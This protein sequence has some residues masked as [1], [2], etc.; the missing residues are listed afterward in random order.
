MGE[1]TKQLIRVPKNS[2]HETIRIKGKGGDSHIVIEAEEGSRATII[3]DIQNAGNE[4]VEIT[5]KPNSEIRFATI[6]RLPDC[7]STVQ[8]KAV[9]H[10]NANV[11]WLEIAT[12]GSI[13]KS[14]TTSELL[15]E[16]ARSSIFTLFFGSGKQQF[17]FLNKCIHLG[18]NTESLMLS[19]GALKGTSKATQQGFAKICKG[20]LN[21]AAHQK[22]KILLLDKGARAL[23]MPKLEIDNNEVS[24][25]HEAAVGQIDE[26]KIFY[27]MSRG[28][29]EK[30]ARKTFVEGFFEQYASRIDVPELRKDIQAIVAERMEND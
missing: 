20:A 4:V 22:A 1:N 3:E 8:R 21:A 2:E 17:E 9:V 14:E 13:T 29:S 5:A 26:E 10:N 12:G 30:D 18:R 19:S 16:G 15:G 23:P 7:E 25:T 24:A 11:E 28:L 6:Q 27:M